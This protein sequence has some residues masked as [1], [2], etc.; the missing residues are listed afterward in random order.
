VSS[1][2][3]LAALL[4]RLGPAQALTFGVPRGGC[5]RIVSRAALA[6]ERCA[7]GILTRTRDQF[8]WPHGPG[9]LM[10][11]HDPDEVCDPR[12][13]RAGRSVRSRD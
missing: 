6:R 10:L 3:E 1:L 13:R 4:Q 9:I 12:A 5:G 7:Q 8:A 2:G 11:D